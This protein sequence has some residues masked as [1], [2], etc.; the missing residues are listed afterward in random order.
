MRNKDYCSKVC[1]A[2]CCTEWNEF[3]TCSKLKANCKCSIYQKRF[4]DPKMLD[5]EV[6]DTFKSKHLQVKGKPLNQYL[7]CGRINK[8]IENDQLPKWIADQCCYVHP[9]L[10]KKDYDMALKPDIRNEYIFAFREGRFE[11]I[12]A[13]ILAKLQAINQPNEAARLAGAKK[14]SKDKTEIITGGE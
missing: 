6:V 13:E 8:L 5:Y 4:K 1:G 2:K 14:P 9:E 10:L 11:E 3:Y 7:I 12:P